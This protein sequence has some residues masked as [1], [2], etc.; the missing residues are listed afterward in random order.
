MNSNNPG[1]LDAITGI[2]PVRGNESERD[3]YTELIALFDEENLIRFRKKA[4][5][6]GNRLLVALLTIEINKRGK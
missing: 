1:N 5:R 2:S 3:R 6:K 4:E